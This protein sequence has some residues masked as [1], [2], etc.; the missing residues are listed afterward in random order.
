MRSTTY[1]PLFDLATTGD[2]S[3]RATSQQ[4]APQKSALWAKL[5]KN[6]VEARQAQADVIVAR[7]LALYDDA[8]LTSIGW[9]ESDIADLRRR[10]GR[11]VR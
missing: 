11:S 6:L 5:Y 9:S 3:G 1:E 4:A 10:L 2:V 8:H 7:H